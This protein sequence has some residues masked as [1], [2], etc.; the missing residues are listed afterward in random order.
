MLQE[1]D[2]IVEERRKGSGF[3][4]ETRPDQSRPD[5]TTVDQARLDQTTVD[6]TNIFTI[7]FNIFKL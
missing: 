3:L 5:Q 6:Q 7:Y 4:L 2:K 1:K